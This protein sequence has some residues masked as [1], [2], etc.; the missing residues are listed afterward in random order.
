VTDRSVLPEGVPVQTDGTVEA[1]RAVLVIQ[2]AFGVNDHIRDVM[3]RYAQLNYYVVAPELFHRDGSPQIPYDDIAS[4]M[5]PMGNLT[6]EHL[7]E[8]LTASVNMLH[9]RGFSSSSIGVVGFCMGGTVA[10]YAATLGI[11]GAAVTYYGGGVA[12][13]RFG[14]PPLLELAPRLQAPWLGLYGDLDLGIPVEQVEALEEAAELASV[15]ASIVRYPHG[16]HG[17][18][19]DERPEN[20]NELAAMDAARRTVRFLE[21]VLVDR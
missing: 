20:F 10:L 3:N 12:K 1:R 21:R 17:F 19:C 18:H 9:R 6:A 8:D 4:A 14:L 7:T 2:E 11:V 15:E 5:V 16:Q 13:G